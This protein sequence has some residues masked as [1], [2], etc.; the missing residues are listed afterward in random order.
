[1]VDGMLPTDELS[2]AT[3]IYT[4]NDVRTI[5][6]LVLEHLGHIPEIGESFEYGNASFEVMDMDGNRIDKVLIYVNRDD[7]PTVK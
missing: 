5:A 6:G 3:G 2:S 4:G 7:E 1:M